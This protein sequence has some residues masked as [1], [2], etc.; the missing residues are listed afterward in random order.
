MTEMVT[1]RGSAETGIVNLEPKLIEA[2]AYQLWLARG[3]PTADDQEDWFRAEEQLRQSVKREK[4]WQRE[5]DEAKLT[6]H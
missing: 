4:Q 2:L 6:W 3:C 5:I 1:R